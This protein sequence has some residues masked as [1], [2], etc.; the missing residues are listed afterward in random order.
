MSKADLNEIRITGPK[1]KSVWAARWAHEALYCLD[2]V[3]DADDDFSIWCP[4][5]TLSEKQ[6]EI[7]GMYNMQIWSILTTG[8]SKFKCRSNLIVAAQVGSEETEAILL[9]SA[10][11]IQLKSHLN[12]FDRK[13]PGNI[14]GMY[15][16]SNLSDGEDILLSMSK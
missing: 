5:I 13:L 10:T 4:K 2:F 6:Q 14:T 12:K 16:Y 11:F 7:A 15:T 1:C 3:L 9:N 8:K